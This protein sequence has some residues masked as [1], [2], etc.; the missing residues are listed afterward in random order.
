MSCSIL[1]TGRDLPCIK[2]VG[3][4][5]SILLVDYGLLGVLSV[6]G[7]EVTAISTTPAAY[8]YFVKP[9]SSGMEQTITAS[10]E[11][12]TVYYDQNV[13]IQLQK[14]DKLT[15]AELQDVAKGHPHVFIQDFNGNYFL[16]G[17]YNGC[18]VSAGT[19]GTGTALADFTGS[20][21]T[22]TAQEQLPAFFC[23]AGVISALVIGANIEP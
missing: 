3:G 17:A 22:F 2:G 5:K 20:L 4:I 6:T 16:A 21:L 9:G 10:A 14:L 8:Q 7:A 13:S 19:I 23:A 18:D 11:N 12:G 1:S 15:Q